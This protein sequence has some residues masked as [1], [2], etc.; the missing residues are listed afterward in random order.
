MMADVVIKIVLKF[1]DVELT[2]TRDEAKELMAAISGVLGK[3]TEIVERWYPY[4]WTYWN[5]RCMSTNVPDK[6]DTSY[7]TYTNAQ[8]L[9][10]P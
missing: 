8:P 6:N 1:K 4:P 3:D 5:V 10:I 7:I 2:L 9:S